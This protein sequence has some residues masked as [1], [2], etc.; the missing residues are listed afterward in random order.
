MND[1]WISLSTYG[2]VTTRTALDV[3]WAAGIRQ[4]ELAIGVRP[5]MDTIAVLQHYQQLG[6]QYRAHH[7]IVWQEH[8]SF[9][10]A[11][12]FDLDYFER[13]TDWLAAMQISAYSVHAGRI[14]AENSD[15][16]IAQFFEH[17][18][19]LAQLCRDRCIRLGVETMYPTLLDHPQRYFMQN[20]AEIEQFLTVMPNVDLVIDLAH[21]NLWHDCSIS[22]KLQ[23]LQSA[24]NRL[25]ELHI[26]D[27]D[28]IRD[29]H[30]QISETTWWLPYVA[31][32]PIDIPIVL[33]SR[34]NGQ[35]VE[36]VH[37]QVQRVQAIFAATNAS[38][39]SIAMGEHHD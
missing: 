11:E 37:Q 24:K 12:Q 32:A 10:L 23:V 30:T 33:E 31:Y 34:M 21:L 3:L 9:N 20:R 8:R 19:Q 15:A 29:N 18:A 14:D 39:T 6:M 16:Q 28:G 5:S 4:V 1:L 38:P 25:L 22:E 2:G 27:N 35:T 17:L 26:S 13:L 36:Q 7:A